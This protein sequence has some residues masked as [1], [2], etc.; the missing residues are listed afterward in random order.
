MKKI[1]FIIIASLGIVINLSAQQHNIA[2]N[3]G[4][5]ISNLLKYGSPAALKTINVYYG[6][7][8]NTSPYYSPFLGIEYE[9]DFKR[10]RFSSGLS[11]LTM[12]ADDFFFPNE[13]TGVTYLSLPLL[14]GIKWPISSK[15]SIMIEVGAEFGIEILNIGTVTPGNRFFNKIN[16]KIEGNIGLVAG[17]EGA[18]KNL[19]FGTRFHLGL[20]DYT[21]WDVNYGKDITYFRHYSITIYLGYTI[22]NAE[23]SKE[24]RL[25]RKQQK[26]KKKK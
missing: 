4:F 24:R 14:A 6:E 16:G 25:K 1:I 8:F 3:S 26:E 5:S 19:R 9:F 20:T 21:T 23:K 10:C 11:F 2:L 7:L 15:T 22:W 17:L 18:W 13:P 12:G